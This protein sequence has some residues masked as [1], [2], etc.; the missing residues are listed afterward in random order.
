MTQI[1]YDGTHLYVDRKVYDNGFHC[2]ES[3]KLK[4]SVDGGITRY[5][6]MTGDMANVAIAYKIIERGFDPD[7]VRWAEGRL[8]HNADALYH[9]FGLLVEVDNT[10]AGSP[11]CVYRINCVGDKLEVI[12]NQFIAVGALSS[13]IIDVY[14]TVT[15]L[16][17]KS[18]PTE[19]IIR[20]AVRGTNQSQDGYVIDR[21]NLSNGKF[22][23]V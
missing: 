2:W 16:C 5:Y 12:P 14:N 6:A 17:K 19:D 15:K 4:A 1:V 9:E 21:V 22:E 8:G 3:L 7:V 20:F 23:A 18:L 10:Q 13:T 11:H